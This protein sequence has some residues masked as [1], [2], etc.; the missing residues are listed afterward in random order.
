MEDVEPGSYR[1]HEVNERANV[2]EGFVRRVVAVGALPPEKA[3]LGSRR[4]SGRIPSPA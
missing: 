1:I 2:P 3:G 4:N